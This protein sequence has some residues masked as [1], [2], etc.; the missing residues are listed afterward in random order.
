M[1]EEK[2]GG[3]EREGERWKERRSSQTDPPVCRVTSLLSHQSWCTLTSCG[4][5][6]VLQV[7]CAQQWI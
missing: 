4:Q 1:D 3:L 7:M 6:D 2:E 5:V